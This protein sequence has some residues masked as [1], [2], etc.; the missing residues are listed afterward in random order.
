MKINKRISVKKDHHGWVI[1]L[2]IPKDKNHHL[3]KKETSD[4]NIQKYYYPN[5]S[6][7]FVSLVDRHLQGDEIKDIKKC[8]KAIKQ[9]KNEILEAIT[10]EGK[11]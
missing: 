1:E 8:I 9:A 4:F 3:S 2:K 7:C 11:K 5:L 6:M 10:K